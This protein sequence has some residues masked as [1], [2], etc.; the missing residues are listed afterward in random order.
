VQFS[1]PDHYAT[2][3]LDRQCTAA[4]IREA[5]RLLAKQFHP[6]VN[7]DS[8]DAK[9]RTQEINIAHETLSD[10]ERR[11]A[12][13]RAREN[14]KSSA[15]GAKVQRNISQDVHL[16]LE[17]FLRGTSLEIRVKDPANSAAIE[18]YQLLVPSETTPGARFRVL[19]A[20]GGF[21]LIR[22]RPL[23]S[24][25]FKVR[26]SDLRCNLR[27]NSKR[28]VQG[29]EEIIV[30]LTGNRLRVKIPPRIARGEIIRLAGEGLPKP[31]GG[32]GDLLAQIDYQP[33]VRIA[34]PSRCS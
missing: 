25:R 21:V 31:R 14:G 8:P 32:R 6:D 9:T 7:R 3:G 10:P 12:Y 34:R 13:D 20:A 11:R 1:E 4:Q 5:Y 24:F 15:R 30:G 18:I 28:A 23:P 22:V 17:D 16:R 29:G 2:L 26:G 33:E 27:I 19:R